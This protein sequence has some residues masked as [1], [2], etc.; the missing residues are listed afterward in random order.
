MKN[1]G[2][3]FVLWTRA[4]IYRLIVVLIEFILSWR[5]CVRYH[6]SVGSDGAVNWK[7]SPL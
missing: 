1:Y 2:K 4:S 7:L 6:S 3:H 5:F